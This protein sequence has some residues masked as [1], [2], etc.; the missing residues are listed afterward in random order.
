LFL[1][2][3]KTDE[4]AAEKRRTNVAIIIRPLRN[5]KAQG[6]WHKALTRTADKLRDV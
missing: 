2:Y 5:L 1:T 6:K 4:R 3:R